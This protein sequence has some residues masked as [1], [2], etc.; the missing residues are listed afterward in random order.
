[1]FL[2]ARARA[3]R[4]GSEDILYGLKELIAYLGRLGHKLPLER[5]RRRLS[6]PLDFPE[7]SCLSNVVRLYLHGRLV[8]GGCAQLVSPR[9]G[10]L[11]QAISL[12][13]LPSIFRVRPETK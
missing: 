8:R 4:L 3:A 5:S 10:Y 11:Q 9:H 6:K 13:E 1:M 2:L 7:V 12:S